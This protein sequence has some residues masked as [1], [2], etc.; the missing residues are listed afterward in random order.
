MSSRHGTWVIAVTFAVALILMVVPLPEWLRPYRPQWV[1]LTLIYWNIVLP[2]RVGIGSGFAVGILL[3][4]LTGTLLGQH[5]LGLSLVA[6]L[7]V[8]LAA[9]IRNLPLLWQQSLVVLALLLLEQL[10]MLWIVNIASGQPLPGLF[11]WV[12]PP[13]AGA[14]LWPWML[15]MLHN[16]Q[17]RFDSG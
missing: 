3:D 12:V 4:A 13:L 7:A 1:A 14:M 2:H 11:H 5:A 9:R 10:L 6:F 16:V 17:H 8:Q 15:A